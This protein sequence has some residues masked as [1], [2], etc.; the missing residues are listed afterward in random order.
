MRAVVKTA[1]PKIVQP[2]HFRIGNPV[3]KRQPRRFSDFKPN[4]L[5]GLALSD[6]SA[7][8]HP[9]GRK[10]IP[11]LQTDEVAAAQLAVDSHIEQCQVA[12]IVRHL[13]SDSD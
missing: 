2:K 4:R 5:L 7:L 11:Y 12:L 3:L 10:H 1:G 13:K 6:G 9:P 8:L